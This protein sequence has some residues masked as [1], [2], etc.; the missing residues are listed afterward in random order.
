MRREEVHHTRDFVRPPEPAD[1]ICDMIRS[2]SFRVRARASRSQMNPGATVLTVMPIESSWS[3][4]A[5]ARWKH[6]S[7][8]SDL[9]SP[10]RSAAT[11]SA[12]TPSW[13]RADAA[14]DRGHSGLRDRGRRLEDRGRP[15]ARGRHSCW[16]GGR[17]GARAAR[18]SSACCSGVAPRRRRST[19]GSSRPRRSRASVRRGSSHEPDRHD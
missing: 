15:R 16:P 10:T 8:A 7:R 13:S 14:R 19:T 17:A 6:A 1:G 4:S 5:R 18:T 11:A 9:V 2:R 12:T 3:L